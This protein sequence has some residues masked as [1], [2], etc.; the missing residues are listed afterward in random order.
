MRFW[1]FIAGLAGLIVAAH[2]ALWASDAPQ[3]AKLRLTILNGMAWAVIILP[4]IGVRMWLGA[5][6]RRGAAQRE[7]TNKAP[8]PDM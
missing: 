1:L 2:L 6:L 3:E 4:A 5:R 8:P 7:A